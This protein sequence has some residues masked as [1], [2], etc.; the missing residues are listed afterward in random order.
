MAAAHVAGLWEFPSRPVAAGASLE[1]RRAAVDALLRHRF[2]ENAYAAMR[3]V[4][5]TD[6][7]AV[8]HIFSHIRMTLQAEKLVVEVRT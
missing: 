3:V 8:V 4:E 5:R 7:G 2:G 1:E 6:L